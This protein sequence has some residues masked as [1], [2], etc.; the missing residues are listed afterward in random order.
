[1]DSQTDGLLIS[2]VIRQLNPVIFQHPVWTRF[3]IQPSLPE[4]AITQPIFRAAQQMQAAG[5]YAG[6]CD[7]LFLCAAQNCRLG[8]PLA[9]LKNID[10]ALKIAR[11]HRLFLHTAWGYWGAGAV[12]ARQSD[13]QRSGGYL[14]QLHTLLRKGGEWV[15]ADFVEMIGQS[16]DKLAKTSGRAIRIDSDPFLQT[17]LREMSAWGEAQAKLGSPYAAFRGETQPPPGQ[18]LGA[19]WKRLKQFFTRKSREPQPNAGNAIV[20]FG[21]SHDPLLLISRNE[22]PVTSPLPGAVQ[23]SAPE[24]SMVESAAAKVQVS[25]GPPLS[26]IQEPLPAD[27]PPLFPMPAPERTP[28]FAV[29]C[30][31]TF[32]VF[33]NNQI[34][35]GWN[36]Q[37]GT[38]ILK[39]LVANR[40]RPVA[41]DILMDLF[42]P[43]AGAEVARRNLHQAIYALRQTLRRPLP[44]LQ[45]ILFENDRYRINA[46]VETWLDFEEFARFVKAGQV[47]AGAGRMS[48]AIEAFGVAEDLYR[49]DFLE[50]DLYEDWPRSQREYLRT[51]YLE[52]AAKISAYYITNRHT[53]PAMILCQKVLAKDH[54][55]EQAYRGLIQCYL[56]QGQRQLAIR[57]Y[58][59]CAQVL[60]DELGLPPSEET[61]ELYRQIAAG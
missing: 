39:Y 46:E 11:H 8:D 33:L 16:V 61:R 57:E 56:I 22:I 53:T 54:Y 6:A 4:L 41:K 15:L 34:I 19:A 17:V 43:D 13:Y 7:L 51:L 9:A 36:G 21:L 38:A 50:E 44:D 60:K 2:H 26:T 27:R 24:S 28:Y 3:A 48:E 47:H 14:Q 5:D 37:K 29:Y 18:I 45:L 55:N 12:C 10:R 1:M 59:L 40:E 52:I 58:Q 32:K 30:L 31:G 20:K 42:W 25:I 49:G 23:G 35:T